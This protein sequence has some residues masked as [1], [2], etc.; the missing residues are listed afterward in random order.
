MIDILIL[1][2]KDVKVATYGFNAIITR[3][4][5]PVQIIVQRQVMNDLIEGLI[6]V[7]DA[8]TEDTIKD[9]LQAMP[10]LP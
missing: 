2:E 6:K 10:E 4:D 8:Y 5:C 3:P 1:E 9:Y 7:R